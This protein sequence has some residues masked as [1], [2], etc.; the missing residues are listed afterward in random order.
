M[1]VGVAVAGVGESDQ[2]GDVP[3]KSAMQMHAEAAANALD[4][5]NVSLTEV[6]ALFTCGV[7]FM[8]TL[9]VA[10]YLGLKPKYS[11]SNSIGGPDRE[12]RSRDVEESRRK[13]P[14]GERASSLSSRS[15]LPPD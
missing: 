6:D 10:E 13:R 4:N 1:T 3:H 7:D 2:I 12:S 8:P 11:S 9:M 14:D 15:S 5:A